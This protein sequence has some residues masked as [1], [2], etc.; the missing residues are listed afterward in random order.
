ML[1]SKGLGRHHLTRAVTF[2]SPPIQ[3]PFSLSPSTYTCLHLNSL[4]SSLSPSINTQHGL[5]PQVYAGPSDLGSIDRV[6]ERLTVAAEK[7]PVGGNR[8]LSYLTMWSSPGLAFGA[9][10][11]VGNF[12]TVFCDQT[13][14]LQS[15]SESPSHPLP[16]NPPPFLASPFPIHPH[17]PTCRP[18]LPF[19][20]SQAFR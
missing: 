7:N 16:P 15:L 12:G 18:P 19:S 8:S 1:L 6:W 4:Q 20:P 11:V 3:H 9:I 14:W 17:T 13:Y 5:F 10:N 2:L